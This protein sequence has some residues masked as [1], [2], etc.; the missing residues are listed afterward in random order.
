MRL[1]HLLSK[2]KDG[3]ESKVELLLF[4]YESLIVGESTARGAEELLR[5]SSKKGFEL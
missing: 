5:T 4:N 1:D 3:Q 2:E